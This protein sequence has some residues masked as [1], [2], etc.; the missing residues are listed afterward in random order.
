MPARTKKSKAGLQREDQKRSDSKNDTV[1]VLPS[2]S[3]KN[4]LQN[5]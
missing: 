2:T 4:L 3:L 1:G 5:E